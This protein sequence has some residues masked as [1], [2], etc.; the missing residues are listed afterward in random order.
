MTRNGTDWER[1]KEVAKKT[2]E[3]WMD[4]LAEQDIHVIHLEIQ[5]HP[6]DVTILTDTTKVYKSIRHR[7]LT[8]EIGPLD[9]ELWNSPTPRED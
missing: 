6:R 5:E 8:L 2:L 1:L 9:H 7:T 3:T 4:Y